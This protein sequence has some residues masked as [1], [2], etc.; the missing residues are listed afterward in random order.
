MLLDSML[1]IQLGLFNRNILY[2][3][4]ITGFSFN[5]MLSNLIETFCI[6]N[7]FQGLRV[8]NEDEN[9][10]ETFCIV[11][12]IFFWRDDKIFLFNRNILYCK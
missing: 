5:G 7:E 10:I 3:K 9:L 11:N 8:D 6:V 1:K 12:K 4:L 2:C